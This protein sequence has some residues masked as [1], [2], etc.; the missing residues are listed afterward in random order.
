MLV[1]QMILDQG[2]PPNP[3]DGT[4]PKRSRQS[5]ADAAG[6]PAAPLTTRD[7]LRYATLNGAK[8][9]RLDSKVGSLTPGKEPTSSS[10][11]PPASTWHR[12][13]QCRGRSYR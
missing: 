8:A 13:N 2:F 3:V 9:L 5:V 10:S 4:P 7:V 11:T 6:R 1:N 12:L